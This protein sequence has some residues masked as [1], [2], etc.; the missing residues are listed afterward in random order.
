MKLHKI[1]LAIILNIILCFTCSAQ[2][3]DSIF[4]V[5]KNE[6]CYYINDVKTTYLTYEIINNKED[7]I[8]FWFNKSD[9]KEVSDYNIIRQ[10]FFQRK[11][12]FNLYQLATDNNIESIQIEIFSSFVKYILPGECFTIQVVIENN[13]V[14]AA[15]VFKYLDDHIIVFKEKTL[16]QYISDT[17]SLSTIVFKD[18]SIVL[19][20]RYLIE[21]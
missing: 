15:D 11:G 3:I 2:N 21:K 4:E 12:D 20:S 13:N 6:S 8:W 5:R 18:N 14:N 1:S 7:I 19:L 17:K 10:Y 16:N 9:K